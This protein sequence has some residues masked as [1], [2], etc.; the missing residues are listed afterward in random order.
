MTSQRGDV[1]MLEETRGS[2]RNVRCR[3]SLRF[4]RDFNHGLI[5]GMNGLRR[6][7]YS[8]RKSFA[9][10]SGS[11]SNFPELDTKGRRSVLH[12]KMPVLIFHQNVQDLVI[13]GW[14]FVTGRLG[15]VPR[16]K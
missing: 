4:V 3:N 2:K 9:N 8:L 12:D 1:R 5:F 10:S 7:I 15:N 16:I 14:F 13:S 6:L 11:G